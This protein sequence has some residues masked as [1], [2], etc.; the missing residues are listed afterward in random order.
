MI[1]ALTHK[2]QGPNCS[3]IG[4]LPVLPTVV[5]FAAFAILV[6]PSSLVWLRSVGDFNLWRAN[7]DWLCGFMSP[8]GRRPG[9]P[10][11][12]ATQMLQVVLFFVMGVAFLAFVK[13]LRF[14]GLSLGEIL[15]KSWVA[16]VVG[17]LIA[18]VGLPWV[19]P[20]I[21]YMIG[22][23][24]SEVANGGNIFE[25]P[26]GAAPDFQGNPM[27]ASINPAFFRQAG[28][29]GPL[30]Q[31]LSAALA[32][33]SGGDIRVATALFKLSFLLALGGS[34]AVLFQI[35]RKSG[36]PDPGRVALIYF[37]NPIS[38]VALVAWGHNDVYQN[39]FVLLALLALHSKRFAAAGAALGA[40]VALKFVAILLV[41][42]LGLYSLS[43][44][45]TQEEGRRYAAGRFAAGFA[46]AVAGLFAVYPGSMEVFFGTLL[47][48]WSPV[49]SGSSWLHIVFSPLMP[50]VS[51]HEFPAVT[52]MVF[53]FFAVG[54][55]LIPFAWSVLL[56][57]RPLDLRETCACGFWIYAIHFLRPAPTL[58]EWYFTWIFGLGLLV[59]KIHY[60]R[61]IVL[62][63]AFFS[64]LTPITFF[65]TGEELKITNTL[66]Y[67]FY[68]V[69]LLWLAGRVVRR[70]LASVRTGSVFAG[71]CLGNAGSAS[72]V[73]S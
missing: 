26:L 2:P 20:D 57:K 29:Y 13:P 73:R 44:L 71:N 28:N 10:L 35:A 15:H 24:W 16:I 23:G 58:L 63:T 39:F 47:V 46:V 14:V 21:F 45:C 50:S 9:D 68:A 56:R 69:L 54:I 33:L 62:L 22:H 30:N 40:A 60:E 48:D 65:R 37:L 70:N 27:Y 36:A 67:L 55:T 5:Y 49:Q 19:N 38:L 6:A 17:S 18:S 3:A 31:M 42:L 52:K 66:H 61:F 34:A 43:R 41:P 51:I 32:G 11:L 25:R 12:F 72:T 8:D 64:V 7:G 4:K 53:A 1:D 59:G